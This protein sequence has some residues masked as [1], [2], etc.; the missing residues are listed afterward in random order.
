MPTK[1]S[2][3]RTLIIFSGSSF[4]AL[5]VTLA[6]FVGY[7]GKS[8]TDLDRVIHR[9]SETSFLL[10]EMWAQGLQTEQALRNIIFNPTD[11]KAADNFDKADQT[12]D[13]MRQAASAVDQ[14]TRM[15]DSLRGLV[16]RLGQ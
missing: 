11:Q 9:E 15:A 7:S 13:G 12:D 10:H 16:E 3:K 14:L 2:L 1:L 5:A 4:L 8:T 6:L